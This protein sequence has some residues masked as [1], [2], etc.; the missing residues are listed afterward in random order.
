LHAWF[1]R[2]GLATSTPGMPTAASQG[3]GRFAAD[4]DL[5]SAPA[6]PCAITTCSGERT[7][8]AAISG[9]AG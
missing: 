2:H 7:R 3:W 4:S 5:A 9:R 6:L 1:S 8:R